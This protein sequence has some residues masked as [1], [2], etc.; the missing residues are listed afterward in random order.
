MTSAAQLRGPEPVP[1][2]SQLATLSFLA[3]VEGFLRGSRPRVDL[4]LTV[5]RSINR[6]GQQYLQQVCRYVGTDNK[7]VSPG[8][9]RLFPVTFGI[10]G[11]AFEKG[12]IMRTKRHEVEEELV[13]ALPARE[14]AR[15][16]LA[17]PFMGPAGEPVLVLYA[18]TA[19]FNFFSDNER[20]SA[21]VDMSW[22]FCRLIDL[23]EV[24][25]FPAL[26][27]YPFQSGDRITG[28]PTVFSVQEPLDWLPAPQF[29]RLKSFNYEASV[30]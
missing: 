10:M 8:T 28:D 9:G 22:G 19:E 21:V 5:H 7:S 6:E 14:K 23:L 3:A 25:P 29:A 1:S 24:E 2:A 16:W 18:D 13:K 17:V 20:V 11:A 30:T 26:R 12:Q 15:S 27:N 4:R